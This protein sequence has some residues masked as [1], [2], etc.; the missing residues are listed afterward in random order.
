MEELKTIQGQKLHEEFSRLF[1]WREINLYICICSGCSL[2]AVTSTLTNIPQSPGK[3]SNSRAERKQKWLS[4]EESIYETIA[5]SY[6]KGF[7]NMVLILLSDFILRTLKGTCLKNCKLIN[8]ALTFSFFY[9]STL[10]VSTMKNVQ[11]WL[12]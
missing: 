6:L 3:H 12:L 4:L 9:N 10:L 2:T 5:K 8:T 7:Q 11:D 1:K